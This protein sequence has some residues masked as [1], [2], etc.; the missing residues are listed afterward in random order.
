ME[1]V[2]YD[3]WSGVVHGMRNISKGALHSVVYC[4]EMRWMMHMLIK[5][6]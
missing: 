2:L 1:W 5:I 4:E 6:V 3:C